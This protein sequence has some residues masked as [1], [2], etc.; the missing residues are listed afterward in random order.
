MEMREASIHA[1]SALL[2]GVGSQWGI[3]QAEAVWRPKRANCR[4]YMLPSLV[5]LRRWTNGSASASMAAGTPQTTVQVAEP[6]EGSL[7][8]G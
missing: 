8:R 5:R 7:A 4:S 3:T 1:A 6:S 2:W